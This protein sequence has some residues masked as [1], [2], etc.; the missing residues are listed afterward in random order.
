MD[1]KLTKVSETLYVPLMGR[2]YASKHNIDILYDKAALSIESRLPESIKEAQGQNEYTL[3]ASATRS[4]NMDYYIGEFLRDYP[5]GAI[6]NAGCGLE[7][8]FQRNDN[9]TALWFELDLPDVI[10]LRK[11]YFPALERDIYLPYSIFDYEWMN[12]VEKDLGDPERPVLVVASGLF[13]YFRESQVIEFI[14]KLRYFDNVW[15]VFDAVSPSGIK[16]T[17]R[18][19]E[20]MNKREAE[21]FFCV[22]SAGD[23]AVKISSDTK[24]LETK[25]FYSF[26]KKTGNLKTQTK[27]KMYFSDIFD[28][29]KSIYLKL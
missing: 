15:I 18:Y 19:M 20:K 23:F 21:M 8:M 29:V 24:V 1:K 12:A 27:I 5:E 3:F 10:E 11:E 28:M 22:G 4:K 2:I 26:S 6:V 9:G 17:K 16:V 13:H 14:R 7:T 25:S